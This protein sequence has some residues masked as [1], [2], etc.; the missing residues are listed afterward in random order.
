MPGLLGVAV[1]SLLWRGSVR[2]ILGTDLFASRLRRGAST[3]VVVSCEFTANEG[4]VRP[5]LGREHF[6]SQFWREGL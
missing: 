1:N 5:H 6:T 3:H 4:T 2:Q